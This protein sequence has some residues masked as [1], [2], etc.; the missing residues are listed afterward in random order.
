M[1]DQ[2]EVASSNVAPPSPAP[3][4]DAEKF[5]IRGE[6]ERV[7]D[8]E[9][10]LLK[11]FVSILLGVIALLGI[12]TFV[13]L[14]SK[15][16]VVIASRVDSLIN[17][18]NSETSVKSMLAQLVNRSVITSY[19]VAAKGAE[20]P[21]ASKA[22]TVSTKKLRRESDLSIDEWR[23][24]REWIKGTELS[25]SD[26]TDALVVLGGQDEARARKDADEILAEMVN[27][28]ARSKFKWMRE[29]EGKRLAILQNF[30]RPGLGRAA[31][32]VA[33]SEADSQELRIAA[34]QYI[35][36]VH[37]KDAF[38]ELIPLAGRNGAT[39]LSERALFAC[40]SL[41]PL[42]AEIA[43]KV[44]AIVGMPDGDKTDTRRCLMETIRRSSGKRSKKS[45]SSWRS[46]YCRFRLGISEPTW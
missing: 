5:A 9:L 35:K 22:I 15:I 18:E 42:N 14:K 46:G 28:P 12:Y 33:L 17:S 40:A 20:P 39:E 27:P 23:R 6:V 4:T 11:L 34:V 38:R 24:L 3:L 13:D 26:F 25:E 16:K 43:Q 37:Y 32:E 19:L 31:L 45:A 36:T 8:R 1:S 44:D 30:L 2:P 10:S 21:P 41:D 29:Q 7:L